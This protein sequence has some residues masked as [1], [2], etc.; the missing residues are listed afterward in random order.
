MMKFK[1]Y[2]YKQGSSSAKKLSV[3]L[4]GKVLKREGSSFH[5]KQ[6]DCVINWGSSHL[7]DFGS[8]TVLNPNVRNAQN[9]LLTFEILRENH[10]NHPEFWTNPSDIPANA[11]PI[12]C[13][14]VLTGHSGAGIVIAGDPSALVPAPL[15]VRYVKKK[16]EYRVHVI[17]NSAV[18]IQRKARKMDV[19]TPNWLVRNL[20]GGFV[21]VDA[22]ET[23]PEIIIQEATTA[24]HVLGL[25]FGAVDVI[26]NVQQN[27]AYVLEVNTACG[28]EDRT[29]EKYAAGF[30][31]LYDALS[32]S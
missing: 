8:A 7:P 16:E 6:G 12:L 2:P 26:H 17:R 28:L 29:A 19:Q 27:K 10:V 23:V 14:T 31:E 4:S 30:K 13:R 32:S 18:F 24:I 22:T 5:P 1:V 20:A 9:K 11:Y 25:D 21:F 3:H 15:Y